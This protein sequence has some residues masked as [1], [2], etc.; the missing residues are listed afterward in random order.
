V[1]VPAGDAELLEAFRAGDHKAFAALVLRYQRPVLAIARRFARDG[2]D[3]EDAE[4][5]DPATAS[6]VD[7]SYLTI[8]TFGRIEL[9]QAGQDYR[10]RLMHKSVIAFIWLYLFV[11]GLLEAGCRVDR[12][13]FADELSPG[14]SPEKQRKRLRDRLDDMVHRDLPEVLFSRLI[15]DRY[16]LRLDLTKCSIDI[17]RLQE[18]AKRDGITRRYIRRLVGLAFLSPQLVEAIQQGRQPVE[19]TAT[20]LTEID[21]PLDW[22][23]QH[24]LLAG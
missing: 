1:S 19:L 14:L 16:E 17:V 10:P 8:R 12:G 22:T 5:A 2:D 11:R 3:A 21:L 7:P 13:A 4:E 18:L 9:Q 24:K 6:L 15:V 23:E 20:R